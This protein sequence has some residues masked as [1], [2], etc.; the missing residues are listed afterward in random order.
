MP[1]DVAKF[2]G[3]TRTVAIPEIGEVIVREP[4][5]ADYNRAQHDPYWWAGCVTLPDGS[6]LVAVPSDLGRLRGDIAAALLEAVNEPRPT[7][8]PNGGC[9]ESPAPSNA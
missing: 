8:P 6:A 3:R 1:I 9:G 5:L 7:V 2:T 4:N